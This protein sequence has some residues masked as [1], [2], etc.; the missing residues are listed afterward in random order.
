M[1]TKVVVVHQHVRRR[2]EGRNNVGLTT[3]VD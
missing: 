3:L 2:G 1:F